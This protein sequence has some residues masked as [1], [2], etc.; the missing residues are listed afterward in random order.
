M[1]RDLVELGEKLKEKV[2]FHPI[3]R[4]FALKQEKYRIRVGFGTGQGAQFQAYRGLGQ[5]K[6]WVPEQWSQCPRT[7]LHDVTKSIKAEGASLLQS[8]DEF[9][10]KE[11]EAEIRESITDV[12][13]K[14]AETK[15]RHEIFVD[16]I[17]SRVHKMNAR[18]QTFAR[19]TTFNEFTIRRRFDV[20]KPATM[21][22]ADWVYE[23]VD[24]IIDEDSFRTNDKI[25]TTEDAMKV[26]MVMPQIAEFALKV[27]LQ[28]AQLAEWEKTQ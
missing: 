19:P 25:D 21:T 11:C 28:L 10:E 12:L 5:D 18:F 3:I 24:I 7:I 15:D 14:T 23:T 20:P 6:E 8:M 4:E 27:Y 9:I 16:A 1:K 2:P 13:C 26:L 17:N 22:K